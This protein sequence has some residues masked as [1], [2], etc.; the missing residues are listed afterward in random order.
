MSIDITGL[1]VRSIDSVTTSYSQSE[2]VIDLDSAELADALSA[3]DIVSEFDSDD[4]LEEIG[5]G[6]IISWLKSEGYT[7]TDD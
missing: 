6:K 7:V 4:L 2:I 3:E 5:T 1:K